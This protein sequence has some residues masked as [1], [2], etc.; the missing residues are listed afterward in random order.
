MILG[1][2][3]FREGHYTDAFF[4]VNLMSKYQMVVMLFCSAWVFMSKQVF[5]ITFKIILL[6]LA[7]L[8]VIYSIL[9]L[10]LYHNLHSDSLS[11]KH[12]GVYCLSNYHCF[13]IPHTLKFLLVIS[14]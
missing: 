10:I 1:R 6:L 4:I 13:Q 2:V 5:S 7:N 11:C 3:G 12:S 8:V 9:L 14:W